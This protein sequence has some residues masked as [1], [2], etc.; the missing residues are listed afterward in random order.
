MTK[1][2]KSK[3]D[4]RLVTT[5]AHLVD[6]MYFYGKQKERYLKE[7][8][9]IDQAM[10]SFA[11]GKKIIDA[12][13]G[14]GIHIKLLKELGYEM[15][16]FD[17]RQEMVSVAQKRNPSSVIIQGDMREFPLKEQADG[18]ICMYGAI[19]YIETEEGI[20]RTFLHFF[21]HLNPGGVA[22]IDT[23]EWSNLDENIYRWHTDEYTL[24]KRWI[25]SSTPMESVY[26]VFFTI[27]SEG[28]MGME[29][30]KQ[31]FQDSSWLRNKMLEAGFSKVDILNNY[32]LEKPFIKES[33]SYL[34]V[35]LGK[36]D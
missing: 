5:Y 19:N 2:E 1:E 14:T 13:C 27:P 25:K 10:R 11:P 15:S 8:D 12:G 17:L 16:G 28:V 29:D 21:N 3:E 18:I 22:I 4:Y 34:P 31:Y 20:E 30:H 32:E 33:G 23:R 24:V 7:K 6:R 26:R 9:F 35:L 36:K